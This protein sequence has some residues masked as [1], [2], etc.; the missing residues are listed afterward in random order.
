[1]EDLSSDWVN[2][3]VNVWSTDVARSSVVV[4]PV[5]AFGRWFPLLLSMYVRGR[6]RGLLC[7]GCADGK[8]S[9][10]ISAGRECRDVCEEPGGRLELGKGRVFHVKH[11]S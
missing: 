4:L 3:V 8:S 2:R 7:A 1:M 10:A 5:V 9:D 11:L 6:S